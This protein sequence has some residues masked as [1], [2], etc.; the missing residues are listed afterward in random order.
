M[1]LISWPANVVVVTRPHL[2]T[3]FSPGNG[4]QCGIHD[5]RLAG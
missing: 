3:V 2:E 5:G 1:N 4:R